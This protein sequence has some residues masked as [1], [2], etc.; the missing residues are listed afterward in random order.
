[1]RLVRARRV[2]ELIITSRKRIYVFIILHKWKN[3]IVF[4]NYIYNRCYINSNPFLVGLKRRFE[5]TTI[6]NLLPDF[7]IG[8]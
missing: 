4:K 3:I 1:M 6:F 7:P 8:G 5:I 2:I